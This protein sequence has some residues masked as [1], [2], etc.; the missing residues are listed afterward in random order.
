MMDIDTV[1]KK[2]SE[3]QRYRVAQSI[4]LCPSCGRQI[5]W[6]CEYAEPNTLHA[7]S[8]GVYANMIKIWPQ[9]K[10]GDTQPHS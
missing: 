9:G 3:S 1:I 5:N 7:C 8:D 2:Y 6:S 4:Y 10:L